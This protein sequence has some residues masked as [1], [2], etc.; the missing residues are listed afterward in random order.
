MLNTQNSDE[1]IIDEAVQA[2]DGSSNYSET[3]PVET[4]SRPDSESEISDQTPP[5]QETQAT[6][7]GTC[8][9]RFLHS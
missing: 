8:A 4:K 7:Q 6:V 1:Y 3:M 2:K 9:K 5:G